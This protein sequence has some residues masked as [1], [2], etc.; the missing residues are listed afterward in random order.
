MASIDIFD[1]N[2]RNSHV[3]PWAQDDWKITPKLTLNFGLRYE[4]MGKPRANRDTI[5]NF[6]QTGVNTAAIITPRDTGIPGYMKKPDSLG[7]SL[8]M[9]DNN[10]FAP[11]VGFAYQVNANTVARG[12]YGVF[13]QRDAACTWI[14]LSI[15]PPYIR[16]GDVVLAV[17]PQA[18]R[19][20]PVDD[21]T[22]VV[23]F[24]RP[25]SK[26]SLIALN[27][28]WHEAYIQQWNFFV[29]RTVGQNFIVK[30]GYV[31]NHDVGLR[32]SVPN[33][34]PPPGPGDVQA[35]RPFQNISSIDMRATNGQSTYNGLELEAQKRYKGSLSFL[36]SYTWSKTLDDVR[37]LDLWFG[38]RWKGISDLNTSH[39]FSFSGV[40]EAPYGKGRKFGSG[41][42]PVANAVLGGWQVSSIV[43]LRTGF[44]LTVTTSGDNLNTGGVTQVPIR[45]RNAILPRSD[46]T[47]AQFFD[48]SAYV[49]PDRY[50]LGNAGQNSI[51]GP[52][53][54][55]ADISA[56]KVFPIREPISLQFRAEF[57]NA[58][59]HPNWGDPG[60]SLGTATFGRINST[61]GTP[62]VLQMGLKLLF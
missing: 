12:A 47:E 1:P 46:R 54:W 11:R 58:L 10:N 42:P 21:L 50:A 3:M 8:L 43:V 61:A 24:V 5:A 60:T 55:N 51:F 29:E 38:E 34:E 19:D 36:A 49:F 7:R 6:Y 27:V 13:Y 37:A 31:G 56:G 25:G 32:R 30:A 4:W 57:F 2:F 28:D 33:N 23:N 14:G 45:L 9:N 16:T 17:D 20:F 15:N 52:G 39:R 59:N 62:R 26:P 44:P 41:I 40:W 35:R 22:P 48:T 53:L 18:I